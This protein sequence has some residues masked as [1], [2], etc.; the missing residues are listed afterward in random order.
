[1]PLEEAI[2]SLKNIGVEYFTMAYIQPQARGADLDFY[3][4]TA[5][6]MNHAAEQCHKAGLKF[7]YHNHAFEFAGQAPASGRSTSSMNG[8][9]RNW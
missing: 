2:A 5:D 9:I 8:W 3:R 6:K 4:A 7:A 1:M